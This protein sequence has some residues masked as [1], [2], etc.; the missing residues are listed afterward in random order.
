M[1]LRSLSYARSTGARKREEWRLE[2]HHIT[3]KGFLSTR[4]WGII[5][6]SCLAVIRKKKKFPFPGNIN[7][8][9]TK[10][11]LWSFLASSD[12]G[13]GENAGLVIPEGPYPFTCSTTISVPEISRSLTHCYCFPPYFFLPPFP[14]PWPSILH[15]GVV[16]AAKTLRENCTQS[17][18]QVFWPWLMI[19]SGPETR[20]KGL[21]WE[22]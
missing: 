4:I 19:V 3:I 11:E 13:L 16:L 9:I 12:V 14:F 7:L 10:R 6:N 17:R 1:H 20:S 18:Q 22:E 8:M 21:I 2:T 15:A 5:I